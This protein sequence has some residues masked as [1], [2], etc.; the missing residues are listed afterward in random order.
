M[1]FMSIETVILQFVR[2]YLFFN[3]INKFF[4]HKGKK[5][6]C[7]Q[8]FAGIIQENQFFPFSIKTDTILYKEELKSVY[9]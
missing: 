8:K 5:T 6:V 1:K 3:I 4:L 9:I 7:I 2:I